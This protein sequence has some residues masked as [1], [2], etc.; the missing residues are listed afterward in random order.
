MGHTTK[1]QQHHEA[2]GE[3]PPLSLAKMPGANSDDLIEELQEVAD[4]IERERVTVGRRLEN[5]SRGWGNLCMTWGQ[6]GS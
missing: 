1:Q 2:I 5:P 6:K 4:V 3:N